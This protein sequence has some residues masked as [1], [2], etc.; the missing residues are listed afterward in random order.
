MFQPN[1]FLGRYRWTKC[2]P[3]FK[4]FRNQS[5]VLARTSNTGVQSESEIEKIAEKDFNDAARKF[6]IETIQLG[7]EL[8]PHASWG[9]YGFPYCNYNAGQNGEFECSKLYRD[10]NDRMM[11]IFNESNALYPSIYLG[12]NA[13]SDQKFRYVQAILREARRVAN[14][15]TPPLPIYAYTKIEYN[16]LE[17]IDNFYDTVRSLVFIVLAEICK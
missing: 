12:F 8:R 9:F 17:E 16:P 6:F 15:F 4:V 5:I 2:H 1:N 10:W 11:F 13:T 3:S 7:R 14:K